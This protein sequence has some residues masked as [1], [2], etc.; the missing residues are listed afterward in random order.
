MYSLMIFEK[1]ENQKESGS[2][3]MKYLIKAKVKESSRPELLRVIADVT[4]GAGSVAF[5]EYVKN[6]QQARVLE[7][8]KLS[9]GMPFIS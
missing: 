1:D 8:K 3:D 7:E 4:L 2:L 9:W 5:G 6:M